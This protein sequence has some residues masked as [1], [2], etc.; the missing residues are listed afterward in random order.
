MEM[1]AMTAFLYLVMV[2]DFM[3]EHLAA[4]TGARVTYSYGR[5]GGLG[6]RPARRLA[7]PTRGDPGPVRGV[8]RPGPRPGRPQPHLHR[9]A[10]RRRHDLD[11]RRAELR[12]HRPD[13]ALDRLAR[14]LRRTRPYLAYAELDF[15]VPVGIAGDN[16]DRYFVRMR[17]M[18]ESVYMMRQLAQMLPEGPINV[19]DRRCTFPTSSGSTARSSR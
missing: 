18:D 6:A 17:E 19:D 15:D 16:Y 11:R 2:R 4:L 5:I 12:L 10:A 14:D 7:R 8:R 13:P 3:Y 9:P 1:G